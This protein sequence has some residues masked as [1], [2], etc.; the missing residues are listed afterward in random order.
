M[1][2]YCR[3]YDSRHLQAVCKEP[4]L[5]P[6]LYARQSS[7]G[8]LY[9]LVTYAGDKRGVAVDDAFSCV[10]DVSVRLFVRAL[11]GP[12][13]ELSTPK[14]VEI[15]IMAGLR[16]ALARISKGQKVKGYVYG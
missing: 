14:S 7:M 10:C 1:S 15:R 11:N 6:Q 5:A 4:G 9:L 3:V 2:A 16:H 8:Y 13:L 12:L